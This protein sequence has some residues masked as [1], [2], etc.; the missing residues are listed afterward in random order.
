MFDFILSVFGVI[1]VAAIF[2]GLA[3]SVVWMI[4][5][6]FTKNNDLDFFN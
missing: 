3:A 4:K 2:L 1:I 5:F 6:G